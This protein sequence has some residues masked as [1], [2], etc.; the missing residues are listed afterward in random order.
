MENRRQPLADLTVIDLGQIYQGPYASFLLAMA[1]ADVIKVEPVG[2][3]KLRGGP[4]KPPTLSFAML[5]SNKRAI[6]LNLKQERGR[7]LLVELARR[8]D[9]LLENFAPGVLDRLGVGAEVLRAANPRLIY[10]SGSG[11]GL[12]G[13]DRDQLAMDH[14]VQAM[15]GMISITGEPDGPP[16]R[17][18]GAVADILGGIHLYAGITTAL[19]DRER[20]G[21]GA[22]VE[23]AMQESMYFTFASA[24]TNYHHTKRTP[25]PVANGPVGLPMS[26]YN[27]YATSD[28][29]L[30]IICV[31]DEHWRRLITELGH[32]EWAEDARFVDRASRARNSE[33]VDAIVARWAETRSREEAY[34]AVRRARVPCAP[35][36]DLVEVMEDPHMHARGMLQRIDHRE[37]GFVVLPHSPLR[38]L[39]TPPM[40]IVPSPLAG[41]HN[42]EVYGDWLGLSEQ[43]LAELA[44]RGVI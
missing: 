4:G 14:T 19:L 2:G 38:F 3:E 36:R 5:N 29:F 11:F 24:Y 35:V 32:P 37:L 10:A 33:E 22:T 27:V 16:L 15:G 31:V 41:E 9:V 43:E 20:S 39:D 6:S 34:A 30:A 26:P 1:G 18:G 17:A 7:E 13:P 12:S 42:R 25:A 44:E 23:V 21:L 8:G 28:G 40:E